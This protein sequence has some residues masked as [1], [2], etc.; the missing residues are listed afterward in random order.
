MNR[1]NVVNGDYVTLIDKILKQTQDRLLYEKNL[2]HKLDHDNSVA[3]DDNK[4]SK[5]ICPLQKKSTIHKNDNRNATSQ[6]STT[7][8]RKDKNRGYYVF[9]S[10]LLFF[11][12]IFL[13]IF[14]EVI[15]LIVFVAALYFALRKRIILKKE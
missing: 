8:K 6:I 14:S 13:D 3:I 5:R 7:A 1:Y 2:S 11:A 9:I 15:F 10:L 4:D 12:M